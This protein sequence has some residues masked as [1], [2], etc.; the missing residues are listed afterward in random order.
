MG[1]A[2]RPSRLLT[3]RRTD[4]SVS[5]DQDV[6]ATSRSTAGGFVIDDFQTHERWLDGCCVLTCAGELD[7]ATIDELSDALH[8]AESR[9]PARVVLDLSAVTFMGS[10]ALNLLVAAHNRL[11]PDRLRVVTQ[12]PAALRLFRITGLDHVLR[13]VS[14]LEDALA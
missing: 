10:T 13:V 11:G 6:V 9:E 7:L 3:T 14:A 12:Q 1:L 8:G 2:L 4:A 5:R